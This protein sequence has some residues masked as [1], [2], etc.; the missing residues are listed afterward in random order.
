VKTLSRTEPDGTQT[1]IVVDGEKRE[2]R[3]I[4]TATNLDRAHADLLAKSGVRGAH[5]ADRG[6]GNP[7]PAGTA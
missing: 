3:I 4:A 7:R 2:I 5:R 1:T 6:Q